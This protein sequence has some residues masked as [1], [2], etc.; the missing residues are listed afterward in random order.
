M[1]CYKFFLI[2]IKILLEISNFEMI[3]DVHGRLL[4]CNCFFAQ[5]L[6]IIN[7][8][9]FWAW[10]EGRGIE[11]KEKDVLL[12]AL[13][14]QCQTRTFEAFWYDFVLEFYEMLNF[15][16][17]H[18]FSCTFGHFVVANGF[19]CLM[20]LLPFFFLVRPLAQILA[21]PFSRFTPHSSKRTNRNA[22]HFGRY[23]KPCFSHRKN[24]FH[25]K[26]IISRYCLCKIWNLSDDLYILKDLYRISYYFYKFV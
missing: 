21:M 4:L 13:R 17:R 6:I 18:Y 2:S 15:C 24:F 25:L 1:E 9:T 20:L 22:T 7:E 10:K 11:K 12:N 26:S 14:L 8:S 5:L 3:E 23:H 16:A 19:P